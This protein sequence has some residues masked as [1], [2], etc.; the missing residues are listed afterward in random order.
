MLLSLLCKIFNVA[1]YST[2]IKGLN[3]ELG[4]LAH[5]VKVQLQDKGHKS[6]LLELLKNLSVM[7]APYRS[8]LALLA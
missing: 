5:H 2:S 6:I 4:I 7:M 3:T 1:H 8:V